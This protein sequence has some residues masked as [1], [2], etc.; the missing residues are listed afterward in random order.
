MSSQA[1]LTLIPFEDLQ[2]QP[3]KESDEAKLCIVIS[4]TA[5][6]THDLLGRKKELSTDA[7]VV[8]FVWRVSMI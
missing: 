4:S 6:L 3:I 7:P 8:G 2:V 1:A 5:A